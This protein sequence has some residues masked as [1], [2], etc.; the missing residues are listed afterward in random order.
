MSVDTGNYSGVLES[1]VQTVAF[2]ELPWKRAF[3]FY[4]Y[5]TWPC[6]AYWLIGI[7]VLL[8]YK[9]ALMNDFMLDVANFFIGSM[10]MISAAGMIF[11]LNHV[12]RER[13][14]SPFSSIWKALRREHLRNDNLPF[15][16]IPW[17]L[18]AISIT[19]FVKL[20]VVIP[21]VNPF[22]ADTLAHDLDLILHFGTHPWEWLAPYTNHYNVAFWL[23]R[24]Y[25]VW[26][27]CIYIT[28]YWQVCTVQNPKLR[29]QFIMAFI[30][31]WVLIGSGMATALS[32]VGPIFYDR[33]P[34]GNATTYAVPLAFLQSMNAVEPLL[35]LEIREQ[36]WN[37]Y[38]G[39][40]ENRYVRGI[41]AMPSMHVA[42]A[43]LLVLLGWNKSRF[44]FVTYSIFALAIAIASVSLLWHYA[45]DGYVSIIAVALIW[46]GAGKLAEKAVA[47]DPVFS[48]Q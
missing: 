18:L 23:H 38:Q 28:F 30:G 2:R 47:S 6:V 9:P 4:R 8:A 14:A 5:L 25:Y 15:I 24:N 31:A 11:V 36:L 21:L 26:F 19:V 34:E 12:I 45:V 16:L 37:S 39:I 42:M 32:S 13:P 22:W 10:I 27:P 33:I 46:W 48:K 43:F 40:V 29:L 41:S 35:T 17:V 20:K 7:A 1:N 3:H 44:A